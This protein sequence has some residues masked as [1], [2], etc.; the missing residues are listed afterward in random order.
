MWIEG[1]SYGYAG[2]DIFFSVFGKVEA[3][4]VF[5]FSQ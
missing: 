1:V 4:K 3:K 2:V 5:M